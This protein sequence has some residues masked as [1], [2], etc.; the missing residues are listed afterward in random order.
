MY[1]A[2]ERGRAIYG[3]MESLGKSHI[4]YGF[5]DK[6]AKEIGSIGEDKKQVWTLE[7]LR[8]LDVNCLYC[9]TPVDADAA[10]EIREV[11]S[12]EKIIDFSELLDMA[13]LDRADCNRNFCAF[14]HIDEMD[15]YF[16]DAEDSLDVFWDRDSVFYRMFQKLELDNVIELACGRGRHVEK[17]MNQSGEITLV[18]ILQK[19]IDA[20]RGRFRNNTHIRYYKNNGYDLKELEESAYS[21][22][23]TYDAMVHFELLDIWSYL[24]DIYRVLR[25]GGRAL[26]HHSNNRSDY[27]ASFGTAVYGRSFMSQEVFAY[28]A[29][30]A[31]FEILE[32]QVIDWGIPSY[33]CITLVE[34]PGKGGKYAES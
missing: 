4:I 7:E 17:Y 31:G 3:Y 9:I 1:G 6:H 21:A 24:K 18:D 10:S 30:K 26:F 16:Q 34:K 25:H 19:N 23:F 2:G 15:K 33:D 32:Q 13:G 28:L 27:K 20:C 22:L 29:Y 5:C 11:L 14:T 8:Q 12:G